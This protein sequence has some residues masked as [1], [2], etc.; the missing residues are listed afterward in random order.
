MRVHSTAR[1]TNAG[2]P[3]SGGALQL[4]PG[5]G[6]KGLWWCCQHRIVVN[7]AEPGGDSSLCFQVHLPLL[8]VQLLNT[9]MIRQ[10]GECT[11]RPF[12]SKSWSD[13]SMLHLSTLTTEEGAVGSARGWTGTGG[14]FSQGSFPSVH[15]RGLSIL[16]D[17]GGWLAGSSLSLETTARLHLLP[18]HVY[19]FICAYQCFSSAFLEWNMLHWQKN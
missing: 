16:K 10:R 3:R 6:I 15:P 14:L 1:V 2:P 11:A 7:Q 5:A 9:L 8:L 18:V 4:Q 19:V 17:G 12:A 13:E